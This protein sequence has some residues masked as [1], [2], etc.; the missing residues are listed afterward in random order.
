MGSQAKFHNLA[1]MK[2][3]LN[4]YK[5]NPDDFDHCRYCGA[6]MYGIPVNKPTSIWK[7]L[8]AWL[9]IIIIVAAIGGGLFAMI[10][11]FFAITTIEGVA[12]IVLLILGVIGFGVIPLRRPEKPEGFVRA[13][14]LSFFALM[15]ATI[16]QPGNTLYNKPVEMCFCEPGT[17][18]T[19]DEN[20]LNP[21]PGTTIIQQD[22]TCYDNMGNPV[23]TIN[24]FAVLG[25]RFIEYVLL[26]YLLIALRTAIWKLRDNT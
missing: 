9:W 18:L 23:K 21:M 15:G 6:G 16:D 11:S 20:V 8:P 17:S 10:G 3:C 22:Y 4:C 14:G 19:R 5:D 24:T 13:I 2:T 1:T 7:R 26:G 12:S 25:I